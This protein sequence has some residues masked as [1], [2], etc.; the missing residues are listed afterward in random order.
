MVLILSC[1]CSLTGSFEL[2]TFSE[3]DTDHLTISPAVYHI[4]HCMALLICWKCLQSYLSF[5]VFY[6]QVLRFLTSSPPTS[7]QMWLIAV[8]LPLLPVTIVM[9][10][11]RFRGNVSTLWRRALGWALRQVRGKVCARSTHA[12]VF[13]NCTHGKVDSV[14]ETFD[15]YAE[16]HPSLCVGPETGKS[17]WRSLFTFRRCSKS[18]GAVV[19]EVRLCSC[20]P[21]WW[22]IWIIWISSSQL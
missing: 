18:S 10:S 13:S 1:Y 6:P 17:A 11:S 2:M 22:C 8:S 20:T 14:L 9:V 5:S 19:H 16:T 4:I 12:F 15:L 21:V 7:T 3:L